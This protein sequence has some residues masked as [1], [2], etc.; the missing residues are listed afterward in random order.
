MRGCKR[1]ENESTNS[2]F[3]RLLLCWNRKNRSACL[4]IKRQTSTWSEKWN[5]VLLISRLDFDFKKWERSWTNSPFTRSKTF[6]FIKNSDKKSSKKKFLQLKRQHISKPQNKLRRYQ[7][8]WKKISP[9]CGRKAAAA[10]EMKSFLSFSTR[11][12][13]W[14]LHCKTLSSQLRHLFYQITAQQKDSFPPFS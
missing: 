11:N 9:E 6:Q 14:E 3:L 7:P 13:P 4:M 1:H 8:K 12:S 10:F 5:W 2:K